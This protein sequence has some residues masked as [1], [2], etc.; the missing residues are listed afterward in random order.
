MVRARLRACGPI[1]DV[2]VPST[3][4]LNINKRLNG[5]G[6]LNHDLENKVKVQ[7]SR[8]FNWPCSG[9]FS[10]QDQIFGVPI[11]VPKCVLITRVGKFTRSLGG[12]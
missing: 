5:A 10:T 3:G 4:E 8:N 7:K 12:V 6:D 11:S 2:S 1:S 9:Q